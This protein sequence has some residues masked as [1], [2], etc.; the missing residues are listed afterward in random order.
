MWFAAMGDWRQ[1]PW[2]VN[3]VA[4]L[5]EGDRDVLSLLR[6]NPFPDK[7]PRYVRALLYEYHFTSPDERKRSGAWWKR[8]A[9]GSYFPAVSLDNP[10]FRQILQSQGWLAE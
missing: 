7:P 5:L 9:T 6:K 1:Y 3:L 8:T 10:G 2:F 4:K